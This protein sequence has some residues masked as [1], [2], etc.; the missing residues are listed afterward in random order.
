[1]WWDIAHIVHE[2]VGV[3]KVHGVDHALDTRLLDV[4]CAFGFFLRHLRR[5]GYDVRGVDYSRHAL[6]KAPED[7]QYYLA[8]HDLTGQD[9]LSDWYKPFD[10]ITCFET[11]EHLPWDCAP[12]AVEQ[13][14]RALKPG[15]VLIA[16]ICVVGM[17]DTR[18]DPTHVTIIPRE[19]WEA[20]FVRQGFEFDR[21]MWRQLRQFWLFSQHHGVFVLRRPAL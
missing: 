17:P 21:G 5:R 20:L 2:L 3:D 18:S 12:G 14:W 1:M 15:G 16:T 7:I 10:V 8:W 9:Q 11:L 13:I 4:G 19:C 6:A